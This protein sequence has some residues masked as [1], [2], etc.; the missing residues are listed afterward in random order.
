MLMN[1]IIV[2]KMT[3]RVKNYNR[4]QI[5]IYDAGKVE[6]KQF[7]VLGV[8]KFASPCFLLK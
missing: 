5:D 2:I 4:T 1:A 6:S 8:S 7:Y 3:A